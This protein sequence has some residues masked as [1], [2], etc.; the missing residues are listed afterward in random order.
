MELFNKYKKQELEDLII[1]KNL[2]Y[3]EIGRRY[4]VTGT[5]IK[6]VCN[7][8]EIQLK[9]RKV[10]PINWQP[11]NKGKVKNKICLYCEKQFIVEYNKAK[12]CSTQCSTNHA[13]KKYYDE[14]I[15][16]EKEFCDSS[17]N[18]RWIK[19]HILDEQNNSCIICGMKNE[20][21]NKPIIFV[22]DHID[23][24]ASNNTRHNLRLV[25]PNC[26]SQLDT[27]KSKNKNSAR[28]Q[29]YIKHR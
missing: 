28:K 14:Y 29:R 22:L 8:L 12:Y 21:N 23:G 24:N 10:F 1:N 13:K 5:Y 3:A 4:G 7:K 15:N 9:K 17:K 2:S 6:K 19:P 25:C 20:W 18:M 26:D 27:Y 16:N 11:H